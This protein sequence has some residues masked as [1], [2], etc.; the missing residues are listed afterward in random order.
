MVAGNVASWRALEKAG[1]TRIGAGPIE[2]DNPADDPSHYVY[3]LDRLAPAPDRP[4][5]G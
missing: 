5:H 2:P 3:R 4:V 1:F